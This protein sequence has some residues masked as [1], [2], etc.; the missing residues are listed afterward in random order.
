MAGLDILLH[1][2][3][4]E[5]LG[6]SVLDAM[7][8]GKP[9][10]AF[11]TGGLPEVIEDGL[12]GLLVPPF[13]TSRFASALAT[14]VRDADLRHRLGQGAKERAKSFDSREMTKGTELVYNRVLQKQR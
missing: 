5:G 7:A 13:D 8:L 9:P 1:P 10:V 12:S 2:S 4:A 6:T 3:R 11:A 14:L